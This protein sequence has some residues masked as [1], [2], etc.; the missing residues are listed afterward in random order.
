MIINRSKNLVGASVDSFNDH[1][2]AMTKGIAG[3]LS[4]GTTEINRADA[5][6]ISYPTFWEQ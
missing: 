5:N 4:S 2:I 3:V 1:R 6:M